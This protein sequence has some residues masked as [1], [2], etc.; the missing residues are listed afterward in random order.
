ME[1]GNIHKIFS[2]RVILVDVNGPLLVGQG[3]GAS[4]KC[5]TQKVNEERRAEEEDGRN[6]QSSCGGGADRKKRER[7]EEQL[8][9]R[10][11]FPRL[12]TMFF[13][14]L[15]IGL[16]KIDFMEVIIGS[17]TNIEPTHSPTS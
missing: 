16:D 4:S 3:R 15:Y 13:R 8:G 1:N 11:E 7:R 17:S 12:G 6:N 5:P 2:N 14:P 10:E 9:R